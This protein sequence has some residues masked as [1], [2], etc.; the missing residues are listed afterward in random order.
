MAERLQDAK[1]PAIAVGTAVAGV[2]GGVLIGRGARPR[3]PWDRRDGLGELAKQLG[4]A[5]KN[6]GE[7]AVEVRRLHAQASEPERQSPIEVVLN[8]LTARRLPRH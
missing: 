1:V 7:L 8:G 5:G 3:L 6:A 2:V 4:R